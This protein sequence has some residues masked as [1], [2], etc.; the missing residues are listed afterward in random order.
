M[1]GKI[2]ALKQQKHSKYRVNVYLDGEFAFGLADILAAPLHVGDWLSD[3]EIEELQAS[4]VVE[5][6]RD[7]ALNYL[8]YRPR[9]EF[10]MEH[11]LSEKG[12]EDVIIEHV[13]ARLQRAGLVDDLEFARYWIDNRLHFRPRG[14]RALVAELRRKGVAR[15]TIA[16]ALQDF[17]DRKAAEKAAERQARRLQHLPPDKFRRRFTQRLARRGFSYDVIRD[18]VDD[19]TPTDHF[20]DE[21]EEV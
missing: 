4:D 1:A 18:L 21:S 20:L 6:A 3:A 10:E 19:Y 16:E 13:L 17:D 11:Y 12:Y 14:R 5:K 2:T 9:S 15:S 8:S 7:R